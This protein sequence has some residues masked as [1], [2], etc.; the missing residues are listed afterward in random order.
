[1]RQVV[2][3]ST[4]PP[5]LLVTRTFTSCNGLRS[6]DLDLERADAG[7]SEARAVLAALEHQGQHAHADQVAAVDALEA[8]GDDGFDAEQVRALRGPVA[9][10]AHAVILAG[11]DDERDAVLL[12]ALAGFVDARDLVAEL[13]GLAE[14]TGDA[15]LGA[16]GKEV[17]QAD[18]GER[19]ARHH[20]VVAA[21]AAVAVE[22]E[23]AHAALLEELARG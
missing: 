1:M 9:R 17:A 13:A 15:A 18:V 6:S 3:N 23:H 7:Q 20:A 10:A 4:S 8:L 21:A 11:E 12:V 5:S 19:A 22:V 14:V 16:G 2:R